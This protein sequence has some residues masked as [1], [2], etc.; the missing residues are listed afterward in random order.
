[1]GRHAGKTQGAKECKRSLEEIFDNPVSG[2]RPRAGSESKATTMT[3]SEAVAKSTRQAQSRKAGKSES[4]ASVV[5]KSTGRFQSRTAA[6]SESKASRLEAAPRRVGAQSRRLKIL[7]QKQKRPPVR[8]TNKKKKKVDI[9]M[10]LQSTVDTAE[11]AAEHPNPKEF[12]GSCA[13]CRFLVRRHAWQDVTTT[14]VLNSKVQLNWLGQRPS[15]MGGDWGLG[16]LA[17]ATLLTRAG[18]SSLQ[19]HRLNTKWARFEVR[20]LSNMQAE[21]LKHL[22]LKK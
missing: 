16:C 1:M 10:R 18:G 9:H 8:Q 17:C 7:C 5:V 22:H 3:R 13:R 2:K 6:K 4:K 11:H 20:T 21:S 19:G 12:M 15:H 14:N